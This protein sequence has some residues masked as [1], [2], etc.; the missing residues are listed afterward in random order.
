MK[1]V[2]LTLNNVKKEQEEHEISEKSKK[3][4]IIDMNTWVIT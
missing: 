2:F 4:I 1:E 3:Q